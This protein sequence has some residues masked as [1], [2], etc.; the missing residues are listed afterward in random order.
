M[1]TT[2]KAST[3]TYAAT[4]TNAADLRRA[5]TYADPAPKAMKANTVKK[6]VNAKTVMKAMTAKPVA[7]HLR[8]ADW[9]VE[10]ERKKLARFEAAKKQWERR[11]NKKVMPRELE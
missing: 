8:R 10:A 5:P 7:W 11:A 1:G 4:P 3:L 6:A 9:R 2:D